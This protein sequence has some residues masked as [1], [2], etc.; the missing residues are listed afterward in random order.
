MFLVITYMGIRIKTEIE[1]VYDTFH[2]IENY[3]FQNEIHTICYSIN[4]L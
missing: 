1:N 2:M 4:L 3:T